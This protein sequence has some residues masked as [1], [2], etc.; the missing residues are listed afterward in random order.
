MSPATLDCDPSSCQTSSVA[1]TFE[2]VRDSFRVDYYSWS[3]H[4]SG[5]S[6]EAKLLLLN[7]HFVHDKGYN[8]CHTEM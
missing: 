7:N 6:S 1:T 4:P 2:D 8:L 3:V 5:L